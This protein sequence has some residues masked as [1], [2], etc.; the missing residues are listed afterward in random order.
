MKIYDVT[1]PLSKELIVYPGDPHVRINRRTKVNEHDEKYNLSRY[2]FS[3]HAG[4]HVD[5]AF[6][7]DRGRHHGR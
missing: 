7:F 4:T 3:S 2:S 5:P 1:V 6:S